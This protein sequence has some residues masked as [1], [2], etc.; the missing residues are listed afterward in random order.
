MSDIICK[1]KYQ[2]MGGEFQFSCFPQTYLSKDDVYEIFD[3]AFQE[4]HRIEEKFTDFKPSYFNRINESAGVKPVVVDNETLELIIISQHIS[5][6]SVGIFDISFASIGHL[7]RASKSANQVLDQSIIDKQLNYINYQLIDIDQDE[8]TVYLP[9]KEMKIGLGGIGKGYAVDQV[10]HLFIKRGLSNFSVNG[11]GDLRV[12][13]R[14]DAPRKWRIGI[15]NPL[16]SDPKKSVGVVQLS[17]GAIASSGGYIHNVNGDKFNNH[18]INPKTGLSAR[19]VI[20]STVIAEDAITA[21]TT[22]TILMNL[23]TTEAISYLN[24]KFLS[25]IIFC[26]QGKSYLS[27]RALKNFGMPLVVHPQ[28]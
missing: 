10:Y 9:H 24:D 19:H 25:G 2:A 28:L 27:E 22:A 20:A 11:A 26:S 15:R 5:K 14:A 8:K 17:S 3:E 23:T 18:I 16:S 21:D 13:S 7:W 12:H 6:N 1:K 4:V